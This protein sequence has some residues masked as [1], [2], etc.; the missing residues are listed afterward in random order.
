MT[1]TIYKS[2]YPPVQVPQESLFTHLFGTHFF[3]YPPSSPAF[4]DPTTGASVSRADLRD[5]CLSFAYGLRHAFREQ[6][7]VKLSR[8]DVVL[9]FSPNSIVWPVMLFG[10]VA[11]GLRATLANSSYVARELEH[12]WSD[13]RAKAILVA[14]PMLPTVLE[15]FKSIG[16]NEAAAR[17]RIVLADWGLPF[18]SGP[19]QGF[20]KM[21]ALLGKGK[22]AK[23]EE[24]RGKHSYETVLLCYSSG[25]TGKPKCVEVR[26]LPG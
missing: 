20:A 18:T 9:I 25:T 3:N 19:A 26:H 12:Q 14:P 13:S 1:G 24:F 6:G 8:G 4:I 17:Q 21:T 10:S 7:G 11:A 5:L 23:E 16:L 2:P 22:L 15:M